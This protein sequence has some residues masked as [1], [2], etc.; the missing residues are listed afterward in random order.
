MQPE[1]CGACAVP[2]DRRKFLRDAA[3]AVAGALVAVGAPR[4]LAAAPLEFIA[5][6]RVAGKLTYPIPAADGAQIDGD[7]Q[8]I[9][10]RWQNSVYALSLSCPH[11]NTTLR[12]DEADSRFLCPRHHSQYRPDGTFIQGRAT[13]G[14]DR[15]AIERSGTGV[16]V[17]SDRLYEQ[18]TDTDEWNA[19]AVRLG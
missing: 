14:M 6:K 18:D 17:D 12:W 9:L 5:S 8:L 4:T 11:Q 16:I 13:R 3:L 2:G 7:N 15:M 10:V 19:A 1:D